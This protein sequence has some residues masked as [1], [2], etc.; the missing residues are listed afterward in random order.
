MS[1]VAGVAMGVAPS[2]RASLAVA[3]VMASV[4]VL[5]SSMTSLAMKRS[6]RVMGLYGFAVNATVLNFAAT[7]IARFTAIPWVVAI[8]LTLLLALAQSIPWAIAGVG[9]ARMNAR[10]FPSWASFAI[11]IAFVTVAPVLFPWTIATPL[12][13]APITMQLAEAI[14]ERGVAVVVAIVASLLASSPLSVARRRRSI[15]VA[16]AIV[17]AV[18]GFGR[19]R[20]SH[21]EAARSIAPS[22]K[23]G[24]IQPSI[25]PMDRWD[26][27]LGMTI[28]DKLQTLTVKAQHDGA[29]LA[30]W[31]ESAYPFV[32]PNSVEHGGFRTEG[33]TRARGGGIK[34][35]VLTG[36]LIE[37]DRLDGD[38]DEVVHNAAVFLNR[39]DFVE[40]WSAKVA[41]LPFGESVPFGEQVPALRRVF[42]R[43][44]GM[45]PASGVRLI[46]LPSAHFGGQAFDVHVLNCFEDVLPYVASRG[47]EDRYP[48]HHHQRS[49]SP[50]LI[51]ITNDAWFDGTREPELH[52]L[53]SIP[54]AIEA[55]ADLV[56]AV[57]SGV[58]AHISAKGELL[59]RTHT[60]EVTTLIV[61]A[62]LLDHSPTL[63]QRFGDWGWASLL[64]LVAVLARAIDKNQ[65]ALSPK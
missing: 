28:L 30:I 62:K 18:V 50:L 40:D 29:E 20:M 31:H 61:D 38:S 6:A 65:E 7:P 49:K 64:V 39:N 14:G 47:E 41:L 15:V 34:I 1:T 21:V 26:P 52:M 32:L 24:L 54:R 10:G 19:I 33:P 58:S 23:I 56:R 25:G 3:L 35:P 48:D 4:T 46:R 44:L 37:T 60:G 27:R 51:N 11:A 42:A 63:Y 43:A 45:R 12:A 16:V 13:R 17:V 5:A 2:C 8:A 55:R 36:A 59:A 53:A 57:N 9:F 22:L